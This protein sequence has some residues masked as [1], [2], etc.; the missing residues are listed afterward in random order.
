[1]D[2]MILLILISS[3]H[4]S[5]PCHPPHKAAKDYD[6]GMERTLMHERHDTQDGGWWWLVP[7]QARAGPPG[8]SPAW[9]RLGSVSPELRRLTTLRPSLQS[10]M[11]QTNRAWEQNSAADSQDDVLP[12]NS[13]GDKEWPQHR[14]TKR[15]SR[16]WSTVIKQT[17]WNK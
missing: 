17:S 13:V 6:L 11:I 7:G 10:T 12:G 14:L 5:E 1:M 9:S 2:R 4:T 8:I 16:K 3:T 15:D